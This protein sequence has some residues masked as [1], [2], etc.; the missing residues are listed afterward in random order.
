MA[1]SSA[2]IFDTLR[3]AAVHLVR[4]LAQHGHTAYLA[5]GCVRDRL[6][7][8]EPKDHDVATDAPPEVVK[9]IFPRSKFV[10]EAFGVSMVMVKVRSP[11]ASNAKNSGGERRFIEV[12]TFRMEWGY[13]DGRRPDRVQFTDAAHDALR[14][15]FT[16]NALFENPLQLDDATG[17]PQIIDHV[18]GRA[19]LDAKLIRA[20][21]DPDERF[22]EDFLRMLR[23][24][25]FAARLGFTI[26]E[27]TARAIRFHARQLGQISRERIGLEVALMLAPAAR[28]APGQAAAA[29]DL[30]QSLRLDA[31]TLLED[32]AQPPLHLLRALPVLEAPTT[33]GQRL[34]L[35]LAAWMLDRH[36]AAGLPQFRAGFVSTRME[37]TL[38]RWRKALCLT[39]DDRDAVRALLVG[40]HDALDWLQLPVAPR[41][42]LLARPAWPQVLTL[43]HALASAP[44]WADARPIVAAIDR[45]APALF[46]AGVAPPPW[47]SGDDLI[48]LGQHPGP[49][50]GRWLADVYDAQLDGRVADRDAALRW[51]QSRIAASDS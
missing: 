50:F 12:A 27:R 23:A 45:D 33:D 21:G 42:R 20:V 40:M 16:V 5:G 10:G 2:P 4:T 51:V 15:D 48:A 37:P 13:S 25:R 9:Q 34:A 32:H 18:G 30:I 44:A 6:L 17:L 35:A 24:V 31:S 29:A 36:V 7:G 46:A 11:T 3:D 8:L 26:E 22:A 28:A 47:I 1:A 14:R 41:K 38:R 49:D 39:N 43:L 19:D